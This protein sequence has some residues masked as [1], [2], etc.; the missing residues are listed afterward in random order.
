[1]KATIK[2]LI[3]LT[4]LSTTDE[5]GH[6]LPEETIM[7]NKRG[8]Q[9][10]GFAYLANTIDEIRQENPNTILTSSGDF[11]QETPISEIFNGK[12]VIEAMNKMKYDAMELGNHDFDFGVP[13]VVNL[14]KESEFPVLGANIVEKDN[15]LSPNPP[16]ASFVSPYILKNV[17]GV[18]VGI[19]GVDTPDV[20]NLTCRHYVDNYRFLQPKETLQR[21]IPEMKA[22]GAEIIVTLPHQGL[23]EDVKLAKEVPGIDIIWSGHSHEFLEKPI[24]AGDTIIGQAGCYSQALGR[25]DI[26][27]DPNQKKITKSEYKLIPV[28]PEKMKANQEIAQLIEKYN[29]Q[30]EA[31]LSQLIGFSNIELRHS[32]GKAGNLDNYVLDRLKSSAKADLALM[33]AKAVRHSLQEGPLTV[34]DLYKIFPFHT[35]IMSMDLTGTQIKKLLER[36]AAYN[37]ERTL[38][39]SNGAEVVYDTGKPVDSRLI[40]VTLNGKPILD[41]QVYRVACDTF[42]AQGGLGYL[43][44]L[45]GKNI[46]EMG[47]VKDALQE[48]IKQETPINPQ[49]ET[50]ITDLAS[51]QLRTG[52][53]QKTY[54][55]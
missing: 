38:Y 4:F 43:E 35:N 31:I 12:P 26:W 44:F 46:M 54:S 25:L 1:M 2:P 15:S 40:S 14:I 16:T 11:F 5:H 50:R 8:K 22:K 23:K 3:H 27:Y 28:D 32:T 55:T 48:Y 13:K 29:N 37:D 42:L 51:P 20:P 18:T 6:L 34:G 39:V 53:S 47:N 17:G 33:N 36:S 30:T 49:E 21:F 10:G 41:N 52:T 19:V 45:E 9:A 7:P 24:Q